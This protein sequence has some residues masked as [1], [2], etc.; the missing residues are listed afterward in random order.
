MNYTENINT[1]KGEIM[2]THL[3]KALFFLLGLLCFCQT[4]LA[5]KYTVRVWTYQSMLTPKSVEVNG[6]TA[7]QRSISLYAYTF[8]DPAKLNKGQGPTYTVVI[9]Y[10]AC[11]LLGNCEDKQTTFSNNRYQRGT[12][13]N[14][15]WSLS[16]TLSN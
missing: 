14:V 6:K 4:V 9:K 15:Y 10:K 1:A 3:I 2:K 13:A 5:E 12:T 16:N 11:S 8:D 7:S